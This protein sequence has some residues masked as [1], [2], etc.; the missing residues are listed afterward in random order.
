MPLKLVWL[1]AWLAWT[2]LLVWPV[3]YTLGMMNDP[4]IADSI[5]PYA[6]FVGNSDV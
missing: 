3:P 5:S 1:T 6:D 2:S 4:V